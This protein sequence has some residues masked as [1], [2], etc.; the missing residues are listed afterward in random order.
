MKS[1]II[2]KCFHLIFIVSIPLS[3][4]VSIRITQSILVGFGLVYYW[5]EQFRLQNKHIPLLSY[6]SKLTIRPS[7]K[8]STA[9]APITLALG[10]VLVLEIYNI[11]AALIAIIAATVGDSAASLVGKTIPMSKLWW[12]HKKS[13]GGVIANFLTVFLACLWLIAPYEA[14]VAGLVS[15]GIESL[16]LE[17]VDNLMIP[18]TVG[19]SLYFI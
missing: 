9:F 19:A 3:I 6:I 5:F 13:F 12:N 1:E 15:A 7:E 2:R 10:I 16:D 14:L 11:E 18:L 17:H 4:Y 8:N